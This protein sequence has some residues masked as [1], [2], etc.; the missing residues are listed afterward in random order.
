MHFR[1]SF[2]CR[3]TENIENRQEPY[4]YSLLCKWRENLDSDSNYEK[5]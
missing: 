2:L 3:N 1:S 5:I 4:H